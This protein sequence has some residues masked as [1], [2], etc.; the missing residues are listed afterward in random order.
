MNLPKFLLA[1]TACGLFSVLAACGG[2]SAAN[3]AAGTRT[4]AKQAKAEAQPAVAEAA[5][6]ATDE[7]AAEQ[8]AA[9]DAAKAPTEVDPAGAAKASGKDGD[10]TNRIRPCASC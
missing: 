6:V 10:R 9:A 8:A 2:G 7:A 5:P 1:A 3:D 4:G